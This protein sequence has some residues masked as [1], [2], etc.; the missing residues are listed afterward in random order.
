MMNSPSKKWQLFKIVESHI[1]Q[2]NG[3]IFGGYPR[4]KIIHDHYAKQFYENN[5]TSNKYEDAT[6]HHESY[7]GRITLPK[8]FDIVMASGDIE[9]LI[10]CM[11][12]NGLFVSRIDDAIGY[13]KIKN[14]FSFSKLKIS[15][16]I[17]RIILETMNTLPTFVQVDIIHKNDFA[18]PKDCD[19]GTFDFR[20]NSLVIT[21]SGVYDTITMR[22]FRNTIKNE[23]IQDIIQ[24]II[25]FEAHVPIIESINN[26]DTYRI[27]K[28]YSK[29]FDIVT[30]DICIK[31]CTTK[32]D[33]C[34]ICHDEFKD[35]A[36][37]T[38]GC[39]SAKFHFRCYK[40][41]LDY[42]VIHWSNCIMC[43]QPRKKSINVSKLQD[44]MI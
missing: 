26:V 2:S 17:H 35:D 3:Y 11:K 7:K 25:A 44:I 42:D 37:I 1:L 18:W 30:K 41:L 13:K 20:C 15:P 14:G 4:D 19:F 27:N 40:T 32:E 29:G 34:L 43:R 23:I 24:E 6:F 10:K 22:D 8:D 28:M 33:V 16:Y 38:P 36:V 21:P 31:K 5:G 12:D 39:C 9:N